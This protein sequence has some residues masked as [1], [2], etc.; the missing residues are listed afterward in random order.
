VG[1]G[2]GIS[3]YI[4]LVAYVGCWVMCLISLGGRPL[5]GLYYFMPLLPYRTLRDHFLG[6]PL[7][8][9]M[10]TILVIAVVIGAM[11]HGKKLPKSSL[12]LIWLITGIYLYF[13]MWL[14]TLLGNAPAPLWFSD[15][16]FVTWKDYMLIPLIFLAACLV[17]EDRKAVKMVVV[18]TGIS[19]LLVDRSA[20][21]EN[22]SRSFVHFDENKRD[23]GPLAFAGPN[24][25]AAYLAQFSMFFWG[26]GQFIKRRKQKLLCYGLVAITLMATMY[27]FS[28][29]SYIAV[30][31]G[32][33]ILGVLKDRKLILVVVALFLTWQAIL[34]VAVTERITMT[35]NS[36][37]QLEAS[38]EERVKLWEA[39]KQT[40]LSSPIFGM[41]YATYQLGMHVDELKDTHNWYVKVLVETGILGLVIVLIM[42][43]QALALAYRLFRQAKDPLYQ[44]LGLGLFLTLCAS[45]ILNAFGDRW[46][47]PEI[48]GLLWVLA[49][50][51]VRATQLAKVEPSSVVVAESTVPTN[52]YMAYR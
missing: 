30:V 20:I 50:A 36:S 24:G 49:G 22:L 12:Y 25:L 46:D 13:S 5:W 43:Q 42:L 11:L 8:E 48:I 31:L 21:L 28:R 26:F 33:F 6:Y 41:G 3:S 44:G 52:P 34:P 37:G 1:L 51:A 19:V 32:I 14:G 27:T 9:N 38:A 40:M 10:L 23:A 17:I 15:I 45:I 4:P 47:Y 18:I 29:A 2:L 35:Q 7:G 16:N 39:A